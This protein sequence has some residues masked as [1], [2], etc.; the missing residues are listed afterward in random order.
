MG[1]MSVTHTSVVP[2]WNANGTIF[3][4]AKITYMGSYDRV[5]HRYVSNHFSKLNNVFIIEFDYNRYGQV[6]RL[7]KYCTLLFSSWLVALLNSV[8]SS[9]SST[10]SSVIFS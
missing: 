7:D 8:V 10:C 9:A 4:N 6:K 1:V 2:T 3:Y 5:A